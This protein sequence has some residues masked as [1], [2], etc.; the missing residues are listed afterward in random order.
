MYYATQYHSPI[1][2]LTLAC[3]DEKLAGLW[4][5]GQK[6]H[7]AGMTNELVF[8]DD[9]LVFGATKLWLDR[10]FGGLAPEPEELALTFQGSDFRRG[11]WSILCKIPYGSVITY[12]EIAKR[13]AASLGKAHMASQAVGA[14]VGRN[15]I[16]IIVPCH[17]VVGASGN[18]TGYAGGLARKLSL[19]KLEGVDTSHYSHQIDSNMEACGF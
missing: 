10:Y 1:G 4:V 13:M 14:A 2:L 3:K 12:G 11:V 18:L 17:R 6:H 7:G 8:K 5:E 16:S 19:L 9:P 15:P